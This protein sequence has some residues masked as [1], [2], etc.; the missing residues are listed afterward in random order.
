MLT[1]MLRLAIYL[2]TCIILIASCVNSKIRILKYTSQVIAFPVSMI[3]KIFGIRNKSVK[4]FVYGKLSYSVTV[5]MYILY[6]LSAISLL[7]D[8]FYS[9]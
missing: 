5:F 6:F 7:A 8:Y 4:N 9:P 3:F 2:F 1:L